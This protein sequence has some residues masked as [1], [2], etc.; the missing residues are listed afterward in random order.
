MKYKVTFF[1]KNWEQLEA[2]EQFNSSDE[3]LRY[4]IAERI[5]LD[6]VFAVIIY[7]HKGYL[8]SFQTGKGL[9]I[10][11]FFKNIEWTYFCIEDRPPIALSLDEMCKN[12]IGLYLPQYEGYEL[13]S[14]QIILFYS[15]NL[16][17]DSIFVLTLHEAGHAIVDMQTKLKYEH[18]AL[19]HE[20]KAWEWAQKQCEHI[21]I[22]DFLFRKLAKDCLSTYIESEVNKKGKLKGCGMSVK[23]FR[24][25]YRELT[26]FDLGYYDLR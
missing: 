11:E 9:S 7:K 10:L 26:N 12:E 23:T 18:F 20:L 25:R 1:Y 13:A 14:A 19:Y 15:G 8:D 24:K 6:G 21:G 4:A 16:S 2:S 22:S 3:A 17:R 5:M